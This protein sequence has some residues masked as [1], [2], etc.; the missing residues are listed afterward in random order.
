M[1]R[2]AKLFGKENPNWKGG[3]WVNSQGYVMV[4]VGREHP[5][6]NCRQY[7]PRCRVVCYETYGPPEPGQQA[8]HLN[9]DKTDDRPENLAWVDGWEHAVSH[10]K[11]GSRIVMFPLSPEKAREYG[12]RGGEKAAANRRRLKKL[13]Q[14]L[15]AQKAKRSTSKPRRRSR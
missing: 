2:G 3:T 14:A 10:G 8:H 13:E 5:M 15:L 4:N 1:A 9:G 11:P 12:R 6:A 7:A